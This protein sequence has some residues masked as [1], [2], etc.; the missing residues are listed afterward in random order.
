MSVALKKEKCTDSQHPRRQCNLRRTHAR[1]L[2]VELRHGHI[3]H[4]AAVGREFSFSRKL[5]ETRKG[6]Y[7]KDR[8]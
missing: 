6:L 7:V 4:T 5:F 2:S 1:T 8:L 3:R